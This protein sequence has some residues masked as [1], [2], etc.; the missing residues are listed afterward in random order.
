MRFARMTTN[1]PDYVGKHGLFRTRMRLQRPDKTR[2]LRTGLGFTLLGLSGCLPSDFDIEVRAYDPNDVP[3]SNLEIVALP[4]DHD[5]LRDSLAQASGVDR[6]EFPD[7]EAELLSY[8]RPDI[9]GLVES[10]QPWQ[11]IYDSVRHLADSLHIAGTDGS[12]AYAAAYDR[13][14][15][16]YRRLA[17]S[18]A[19]RDDAIRDQIGADNELALRVAGA[20]DSLRD[21][22]GTALAL[23]PTLADSAIA[24]AGREPRRAS[25]DS[26]GVASFTLEPGRWWFVAIWTDPE[27]PFREYY[28]NVGLSVSLMNSRS[29][30]LHRDNADVRW[31]Y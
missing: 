24:K 8:E 31:R 3:L 16:Q 7:L 14:R 21:W 19:E 6:P 20:A 11:A 15:Q 30:P 9:S 2:H 17:Q 13:L 5:A 12:A 23:Y 27:N 25:T 1:G 18:T 4:F 28:W 10:L 29:I 26:N 22:E